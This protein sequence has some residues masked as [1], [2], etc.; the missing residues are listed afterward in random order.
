MHVG[1]DSLP[2]EEVPAQGGST[3]VAEVSRIAPTAAISVASSPMDTPWHAWPVVAAG[4]M[5]IGDK[6]MLT[7]ARTL[8]AAAVELAVSPELVEAAQAE[9]ADDMDGEEY[10]SPIPEDQKPP[11][12]TDSGDEPEN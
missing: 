6:A 11:V 1:I 8:A 5:S 2:D 12:P 3:D 9:F 10:E 4:G 7:A